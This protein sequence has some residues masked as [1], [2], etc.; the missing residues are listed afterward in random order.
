MSLNPSPELVMVAFLQSLTQFN[1][2]GVTTILPK[3][4]T[5][6][7]NGNLRDNWS[8]KT[9]WIT[10]ATINGNPVV[11]LRM[12]RAVV[13]INCWARPDRPGS[14]KAPFGVANNVA[15]L[16]YDATTDWYSNVIQEMPFTGY[17]SVSVSSLAP[18]TEP[19]RIT[20]EESGLARYL[21][22]VELVYSPLS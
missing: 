1:D 14:V 3:I 11:G 2:C 13:A 10:V 12:R 9:K 22:D 7:A 19:R 21:L 5:T 6:D 4:S 16:V 17:K 15:E 8:G 18:L 20:N